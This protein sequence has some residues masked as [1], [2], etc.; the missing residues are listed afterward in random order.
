MAEGD[1]EDQD[2]EEEDDDGNKER[3]GKWPSYLALHRSST[4]VAFSK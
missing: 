3:E 4:Q 1:G 2:D